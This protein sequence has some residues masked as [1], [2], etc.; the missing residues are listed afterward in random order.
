MPF[1]RQIRQPSITS[2]DRARRDAAR[3]TVPETTP[4]SLG[5]AL[6]VA[7][8]NAGAMIEAIELQTAEIERRVSVVN[9]RVP[10][11]SASSTGVREKQARRPALSASAS[12][13]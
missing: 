12:F 1:R 5:S 4:G 8:T 7:V 3:L 2:A 10:T 13:G 6:C 11:I 9:R